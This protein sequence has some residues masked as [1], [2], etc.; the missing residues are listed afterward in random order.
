MKIIG[1]RRI[2][3]TC[4]C[5]VWAG[6][7]ATLGL[8]VYRSP[9]LS[10]TTVSAA[11]LAVKLNPGNVVG[12]KKCVECHKSEHARWKLTVHASNY[13][14]L[15]D[16]NAA[17]YLKSVDKAVCITC[18]GTPM[19]AAGM[20][21]ANTGVSCE[22]CHGG[23]KNWFAAHSVYVKGNPKAT[24]A[25]ETPMHRKKRLATCQAAGKAGPR[26]LYK[27]ALKCFACHIV[28]D[29]T[30][31]TKTMHK[32]GQLN[33]EF[34]SWSNGSVRHNFQVDKTKNEVVSSLWLHPV[35]NENAGKRVAENRKRQMYVIGVLAEL[36]TRLRLRAT[37]KESGYAGKVAGPIAFRVRSKLAKINAAADIGETK[38]VAKMIPKLFSR[39]SKVKAGDE[40]FFNAE[41][42]K[43]AAAAKDFLAKH[44]GSKLAKL[45]KLIPERHYSKQYTGPKD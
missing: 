31:L 30:L 14:R 32:P 41:A 6:V 28:G 37:A 42:D 20:A 16:P 38:V 23:A 10:T 12:P 36:E 7:I 33:F 5:S 29:E 11:G 39:I 2:T 1:T 44:D 27:V 19:G 8:T 17:A 15:M 45:D 9:A 21:I 24:R 13:K 43:V 4:Y 22:S 35:P 3:V 40:K 34:A 25:M 26:E 18:H